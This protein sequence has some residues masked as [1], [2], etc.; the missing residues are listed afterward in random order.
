MQST[1]LVTLQGDVPMTTSRIV[2]EVFEKRHDHVL[3]AIDG[4][5]LKLKNIRYT[6]IDTKF[7]VTTFDVQIPYAVRK[8]RGFLISSYGLH[9]WRW[10]SPEPKQ[11]QEKCCSLT[12]SGACQARSHK[13]SPHN[14]TQRHA[15]PGTGPSGLPD[16][17]NGHSE[18]L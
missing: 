8:D 7:M 1:E 10:V 5:L 15:R 17:R 13:P 9:C 14:R 6:D 12:S 4:I 3:R 16:L 11:W 2:A 18:R